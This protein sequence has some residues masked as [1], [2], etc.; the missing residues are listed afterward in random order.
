M[1]LVHEDMRLSRKNKRKQKRQA[2]LPFKQAADNEGKAGRPFA[3]AHCQLAHQA[4]QAQ[5]PVL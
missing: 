2:P 5:P 3:R 1:R 4:C